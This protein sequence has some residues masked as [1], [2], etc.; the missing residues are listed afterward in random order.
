VLGQKASVI[1]GKTV[2]EEKQGKGNRMEKVTRKR[3]GGCDISGHGL[4]RNNSR[5]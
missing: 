2:N 3:D 4:L 5:C 1:R